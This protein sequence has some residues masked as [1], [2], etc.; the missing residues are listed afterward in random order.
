MIEEPAMVSTVTEKR[1]NGDDDTMDGPLLLS[2]FGDSPLAKFMHSLRMETNNSLRLVVD[3]ANTHGSPPTFPKKLR[4]S[5]SYN[6][7][8][9]S[10]KP[11]VQRSKSYPHESRWK[12]EPVLLLSGY[13]R[14]QATTKTLED[15]PPVLKGRGNDTGLS[16]HHPLLVPPRSLIQ[17]AMLPQRRG[18]LNEE[19]SCCSKQLLVMPVRR[20]SWEDGSSSK[21]PTTMKTSSSLPSLS[22]SSPNNNNTNVR[23]TAELIAIALDELMLDDEFDISDDNDDVDVDVLVPPLLQRQATI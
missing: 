4:R 12:S 14:Q 2:T 9:T 19:D 21:S 17:N 1:S 15:S 7:N 18:T 20:G 6:P 8:H 23:S 3:N 16:S 22:L 5:H 13:S 10:K 11:R